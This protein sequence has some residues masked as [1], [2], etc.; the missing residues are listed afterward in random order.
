MRDVLRQKDQIAGRKDEGPLRRP[1]DNLTLDQLDNL[2]LLMPITPRMQDLLR[3]AASPDARVGRGYLACKASS[4]GRS[5][6]SM[7]INDPASASAS[8]RYPL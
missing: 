6:C 7:F 2:I 8:L 3:L 1:D 4:A 5:Q